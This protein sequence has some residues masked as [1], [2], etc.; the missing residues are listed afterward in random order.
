[1]YQQQQSAPGVALLVD[2]SPEHVS[3]YVVSPPTYSTYRCNSNTVYV[4]TSPGIP[5]MTTAPSY[6]ILLGVFLESRQ[7]CLDSNFPDMLRLVESAS[8][9]GC[10]V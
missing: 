7:R 4:T 2:P 6:Y 8:A 10:L 5:P 1:M 3:K 9:Y